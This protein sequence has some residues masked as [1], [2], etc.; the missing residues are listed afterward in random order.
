MNNKKHYLKI[1]IL[2]FLICLIPV[3]MMC[4]PTS[5]VPAKLVLHAPMIWISH[6]GGMPCMYGN[7]TNVGGGIAYNGRLYIS[8]NKGERE[9]IT[10]LGDIDPGETIS[11]EKNLEGYTF[12]DDVNCTY[13]LD[14]DLERMLACLDMESAR[15]SGG[16]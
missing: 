7:V 9:Y 6:N 3:L 15:A 10:L 2:C 8:A 4:K 1:A 11:V 5:T 16:D 12:V 13:W 14:W